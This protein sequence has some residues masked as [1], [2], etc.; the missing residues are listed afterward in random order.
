MQASE[1]QFNHGDE[2]FA[3]STFA[4]TL[5]YVDSTAYIVAGIPSTDIHVGGIPSMTAKPLWPGEAAVAAMLTFDVDGESLWISREAEN[6]QRVG[7]LSQGRYGPKVALGLILDLLDELD[8]KATFFVPGWVAERY[9]L[10]IREIA[11]RG[12]E[13]GHHGYLHEWPDPNDPAKEEAVLQRGLEILANLTG[14][15]PVG[16]RS[17]AWEF[18]PSTLRFLRKFGFL[19]SSNLMDD[20][21]PYWH[22]GEGAPLLELPVQWVLDDAPFFMFSTRTPRPI[23]PAAEVEQIWKEE[24]DG[25]MEYG[26]LFNLTMHPQFIGRP[27]RLQMLRRVVAAL[28]Q[29]GAW[30]ATGRQIAEFWAAQ[31]PPRETGGM[32]RAERS[33]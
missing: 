1:A 15:R 5:A 21:R 9:P 8:V 31:Y 25:L 10:E 3:P 12:H 14:Y 26:G 23:R 18:T 33:V 28:R 22:A 32:D 20:I 17:P 2:I 24:L 29:R 4:T 6:A 27:G 11:A 13:L 7:V 19:Y 16:Y 30:L